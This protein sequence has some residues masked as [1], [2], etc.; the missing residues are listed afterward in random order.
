MAQV[1]W[2]EMP[3]LQA[4]VASAASAGLCAA[5]S[6]A[7]G[8]G[9]VSLTWRD[10]SD[11]KALLSTVRALTHKNYAV[12]FALHFEP[13]CLRLALDSGIPM[14]TFSWGDPSKYVDDVRSAGALLGLQVTSSGSARAA[15]DLCPDFLIVQGCE[16]GGHVQGHMPLKDA[17]ADVLDETGN[18]P[19]FA[20]GGLA[21]GAD[22]AGVMRLGAA[23]G[24]FG[25]RFVASNESDAHPLYQTKIL[26][27]RAKDTVLTTCFDGDWPYAL[28]RVL[29]NSTFDRWEAAGCPAHGLR[30]REGEWVGATA[31]GA[32]VYR[33]DDTLPRFDT[34]GDCEAMAMYA[35]TSVDRIHSILPA[36]EIVKQIWAEAQLEAA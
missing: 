35:G 22:L 19:V 34:T 8:I 31:S 29:R 4:P 15:M 14:I 5:V 26:E 27:S 32:P 30:P 18:V 28:H 16:A 3:I 11:A 1:R 23:G 25:S 10:E 7:G 6:N 17:L 13:R 9:S 36:A 24:V 2:C 33:Y 21:T 12:N 20:A